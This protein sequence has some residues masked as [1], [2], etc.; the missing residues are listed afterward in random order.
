MIFFFLHFCRIICPWHCS[1]SVLVCYAKYIKNFCQIFIN[2]AEINMMMGDSVKFCTGF[3]S[4]G[5]LFSSV[6]KS[7]AVGQK[8]IMFNSVTA[9]HILLKIV[10]SVQGLSCLP[11][12]L[13]FSSC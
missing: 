8:L 10:V 1:Q 6:C 13:L 5:T 9:I 2:S 3:H 12:I 4:L 11:L 7:G